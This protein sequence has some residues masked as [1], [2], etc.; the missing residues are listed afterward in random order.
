[1]STPMPLFSQAQVLL[2]SEEVLKMSYF[3]RKNKQTKNFLDR[4]IFKNTIVNNTVIIHTMLF[5]VFK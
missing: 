4:T 5:V 1:M 2:A 3:I